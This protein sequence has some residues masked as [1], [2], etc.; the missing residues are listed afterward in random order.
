MLI[1]IAISVGFL[2]A[3]GLVLAGLLL[4]AEKKILNY[5]TCHIDINAGKK[6]LDVDGGA[7]LL[8]S[9][10][11]KDI[12]IP[13]A[14]GGRGSCAYCKLKVNAGGGMI[15]PVEEPYLSADERKDNVRL[16][17]Q[18]KVRKDLAVR[19]ADAVEYT[20][21]L[22]PPRALGPARHLHQRAA[23]RCRQLRERLDLRRNRPRPFGRGWQSRPLFPR[24]P[25]L[26]GT[27]IFAPA[28]LD[29]SGNSG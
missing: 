28:R 7:S 9:L 8:S 25:E 2:L 1:Q 29:M 27:L 20:T 18:V 4:L 10:A 6:I 14:C 13:S 21:N 5:G 11:Q 19:V 17:C 3:C 26:A 22:F 15:G 24:P 16:A 23:A 12:F